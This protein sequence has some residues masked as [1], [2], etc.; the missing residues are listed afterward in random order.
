[1]GGDALAPREKKDDAM[2]IVEGKYRRPQLRNGRINYRFGWFFVTFQVFQN[3]SELGAIVGEECVLNALGEAVKKLIETLHDFNPEVYVDCFVVMPNHV[4]IVLKIENRPANDE[5]HLGKIMRKLKSLAAREYRILKGRGLARDIGSHLW[6]E[7]YWEKI[8][9]SHEQLEAIRRYVKEN[10][11]R[12]STDRFGPVTS[13]SQGNLRLLD[14][15]F[16]AFV[17]S[18]DARGGTMVAR[19]WTRGATPSRPENVLESGAVAPRESVLECGAVEPREK[20][21]IISTFTSAQEREV[22]RRL[23]ANGRRFIAVCPGG[24]PAVLPDNIAKSVASGQALLI[25][26]V[27]SGTGVNKQRAIWCN[28]Y[29]IRRAAKVWCGH[30]SSGGTLLSILKAAGL[31]PLSPTSGH[32]RDADGG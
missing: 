21:V 5:H 16:E 29:V 30:V 23:I 18:Q 3:K 8:V 11:K 26:P 17:A 24:I 19:E 1:M 6:Q 15:P 7:N 31:A 22:L 14:E 2:P 28:E 13:F 25:S 20:P 27:V 10:P 9:T 4:H 12:W 32:A